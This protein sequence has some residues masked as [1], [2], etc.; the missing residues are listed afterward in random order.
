M[1]ITEAAE[2]QVWQ[3]IRNAIYTIPD[4]VLSSAISWVDDKD[5][6]MIARAALEAMRELED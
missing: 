2:L 1:T 6:R 4:E 5:G 3:A